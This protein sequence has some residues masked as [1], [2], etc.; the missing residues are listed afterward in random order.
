MSHADRPYLALSLVFLLICAGIVGSVLYIYRDDAEHPDASSKKVYPAPSTTASPG[1][2]WRQQPSV[3]MPSSPTA[4]DSLMQKSLQ[5]PALP[6]TTPSPAV[7]ASPP[8]APVSTASSPSDD[9]AGTEPPSPE[10][11]APASASALSEKEQAPDTQASPVHPAQNATAGPSEQA[12]AEIPSAQAENDGNPTPDA[13]DDREIVPPEEVILYGKGVP[14]DASGGVVRGEIPEKQSPPD[15]SAWFGAPEG[16]AK[17]P[18]PSPKGQDS[19]V[20][21][22]FVQELARFLAENYWPAETHPQARG[23]CIST[24]GVKLANTIFGG[25]L[26]GFNANPDRLSRER[27]RVL[28]YFFMP[29]MIRALY[30]LYAERFIKALDQ[31][32][33]AQRRGP[34]QRPLSM[35]ERA[36][37]YALY[38]AMARAVAGAV[39]AC[40]SEPEMRALVAAYVEAEAQAEQAARHFFAAGPRS[41]SDKA[42]SAK[43]YQAAVKQRERR[44]GALLAALRRGGREVRTLNA[45]ALTHIALWLHRRDNAKAALALAEVIDQCAADLFTKQRNLLRTTNASRTRKQ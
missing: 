45:D 2:R 38:G 27:G 25:Q 1:T 14:V 21:L 39:R 18:R 6:S 12:D 40:A 42:A 34:E 35:K 29:S 9:L 24:A 22:R 44:K 19:V 20:R 32:A 30:G 10:P 37:M 4:S 5:K 28:N 17:E 41:G 36:E 33:L 3:A 26:L 15:T 8:P 16:A 13:E 23:R 43:L 31:E 7:T 11:D